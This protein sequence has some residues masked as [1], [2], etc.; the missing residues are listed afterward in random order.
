MNMYQ[1]LSGFKSQ[2][3][4]DVSESG[5]AKTSISILNEREAS[6]EFREKQEITNSPKKC[7]VVVLHFDEFR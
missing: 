4:A 5:K 6:F 2:I 7:L 1:S 3:D